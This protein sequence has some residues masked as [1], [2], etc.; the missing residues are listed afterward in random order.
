MT[1]GV[2]L[3]TYLLFIVPLTTL[4]IYTRT[5]EDSLC[6]FNSSNPDEVS[7]DPW[8]ATPPGLDSSPSRDY[9]SIK[10]AGSYIYTWVERGSMR[11]KCLAQERNA[12]H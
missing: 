4:A 1:F 7:Y 6:G 2:N 10:F 9:P 12:V 5:N 11:V 3:F 8:I